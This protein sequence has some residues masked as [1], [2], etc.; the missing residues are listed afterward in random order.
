MKSMAQKSCNEESR[1]LR[2]L[3]E[4]IE[5]LKSYQDVSRL[6]VGALHMEWDI[7]RAGRQWTGKDGLAKLDRLPGRLELLDGKLCASETERSDLLAGLLENLGLDAV[8][9]FGRIDDWQK[10]IAARVE[11]ERNPP[12]S[13]EIKTPPRHWNC[14]VIEFPSEE[15]AWFA[16]HEV[17]YEHGLPL[18]YSKSAADPGWTG[19]DGPDAGLN[20]LEKFRAALSKP[21]LKLS[22]FEIARAK[23]ALLNKLG[24]MVDDSGG[25]RDMDALLSWLETWLA[26][27]CLELGGVTPALALAR[28]DGRLEVETLL[29]RMRGGLPG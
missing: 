24:Q 10:A 18:A 19:D 13:G 9:R 3:S 28:E 1:M 16:I 25:S 23:A 29:E 6:N 2:E 26:E 27:P 20:Q 21:V 11:A 8:V 15:D 5:D 14:R 17:Y 12:D 22:D 7:G 4:T